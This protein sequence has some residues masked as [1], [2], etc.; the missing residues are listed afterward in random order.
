MKPIGP[1]H[2]P[3]NPNPSRPQSP[4]RRGLRPSDAKSAA[5]FLIGPQ[6]GDVL[7]VAI[8]ARVPCLLSAWCE[9]DGGAVLRAVVPRAARKQRHASLTHCWMR[10][11]RRGVAYP[12]YTATWARHGPCWPPIVAPFRSRLPSSAGAVNECGRNQAGGA[13]KRSYT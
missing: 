13:E 9:N 6:C 5:D 12:R 10:S 8:S 2:V 3:Q 4:Y 7:E 1:Q 11:W